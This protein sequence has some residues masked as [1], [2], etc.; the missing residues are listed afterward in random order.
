MAETT[1]NAAPA[2]QNT[3]AAKPKKSIIECFLQGCGKGFDI[4]IKQ[5]APAMIL[6]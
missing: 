3:P 6:G 2:A 5:I 4:G 1:M